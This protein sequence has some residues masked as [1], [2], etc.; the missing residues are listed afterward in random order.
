MERKEGL[1][2]EGS[3]GERNEC[4]REGERREGVRGMG[5]EVMASFFKIVSRSHR[6]AVCSVLSG[7]LS[8]HDCY[9]GCKNI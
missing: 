8:L 7:C 2:E 3:V 5:R 1:R 4:V 9:V 6:H